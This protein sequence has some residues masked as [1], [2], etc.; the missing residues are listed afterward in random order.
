LRKS[1]EY[2]VTDPAS[3]DFVPPPHWRPKVGRRVSVQSVERRAKRRERYETGDAEASRLDKIDN[4][5]AQLEPRAAREESAVDRRAALVGA[6]LG[7]Q[8]DWR[9]S[10]ARM[11]PSEQVLQ[12]PLGL[13]CWTI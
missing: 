5:H 7:P 9:S 4:L 2:A 1:L 10:F 11:V 8:L 6:L 12:V 13:A 3:P